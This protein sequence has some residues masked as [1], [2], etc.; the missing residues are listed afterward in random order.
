MVF[1]S[2]N[3]GETRC[4]LTSWRTH[5]SLG[6]KNQ[7]WHDK[8]TPVSTCIFFLSLSLWVILIL[9][10]E[11]R[12]SMWDVYSTMDA[13]C[14]IGVA[15]STVKNIMW[16]KRHREKQ[17]KVLPKTNKQKKPFILI[18]VPGCYQCTELYKILKWHDIKSCFWSFSRHSFFFS[19]GPT[20]SNF[21]FKPLNIGL[22]GHFKVNFFALMFRFR[23]V[24]SL[25]ESS[26]LTADLHLLRL[27]Q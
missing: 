17:N 6:P 18:H 13:L 1:P 7:H 25:K 4:R 22:V 11:A 3:A 10:V 14:K 9:S 15:S 20:F 2:I 23:A 12:I 16:H 27:L 19:L 26:Q 8:T 24:L 5:H 21:S